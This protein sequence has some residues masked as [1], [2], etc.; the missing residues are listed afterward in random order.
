MR[1]MQRTSAIRNTDEDDQEEVTNVYRI[2]EGRRLSAALRAVRVTDILDMR[3][4]VSTRMAALS[5]LAVA[6]NSGRGDPEVV[7]LFEYVWK[8]LPR[9]ASEATGA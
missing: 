4:P 5:D 6:A 8:R 3:I 2:V 9:D 7:A 1:T